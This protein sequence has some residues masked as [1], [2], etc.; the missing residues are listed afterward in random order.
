MGLTIEKRNVAVEVYDE[1][2]DF[3]LLTPAEK[4]LFKGLNTKRAK[5][6]QENGVRKALGVVLG[7]E[8]TIA[9]DGEE[10]VVTNAERLAARTF[11]EAMQNPSTTK[12]K[13]I[14]HIMGEDKITVDA[15]VEGGADI[16]LGIVKDEDEE[17]E[18]E[19]PDDS[20]SR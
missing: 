12:L 2:K 20:D 19:E 3:K 8:S 17:E 9:I 7:M 13:D 18:V 1:F 14:A 10:V 4:D 11:Q 5:A 6:L 16:F 15:K